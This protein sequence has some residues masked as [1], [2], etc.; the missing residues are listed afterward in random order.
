MEARM[1]APGLLFELGN[2]ILRV[3]KSADPDGAHA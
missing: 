3:L 2:G 1:M